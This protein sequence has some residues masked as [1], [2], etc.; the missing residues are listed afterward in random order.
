MTTRILIA[1]DQEDVRNGFRLILDSQPD[2]TVVGEAADG[3]E[4]VELARTLRPDV[5]IADIRM[6]RLDGL[7]VTRL[8][9]GPTAEHPVRVVVVTTFDLDDYVHTALRNGACGFLLKRSG[10]NLLIEGVRAAMAG[11]TLIGPQLTVRLL[12]SLSAPQ[13]RPAP[14][15]P[16]AAADPLTAREREIALLVARGLTNAEVGAELFISPGTAKTHVANIQAKLAVRNR[17]G[18]AAWAWET[19]LAG[20]A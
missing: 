2:M 13:P 12:R 18:I 17:V 9:A 16:A 10:P 19:G 20:K 4:A 15:P 8:L 11:D 1:D 14:E 6:P 5:V 7:E 3:A